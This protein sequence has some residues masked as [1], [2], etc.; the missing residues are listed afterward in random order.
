MIDAPRRARGLSAC[1]WE[2]TE[3]GGAW[4]VAVAVGGVALEETGAAGESAGAVL[5]RLVARLRTK[6]E[7]P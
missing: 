7:R 1:A 4:L 5:D 3:E 6:G 2:L